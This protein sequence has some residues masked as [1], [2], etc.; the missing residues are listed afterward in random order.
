MAF[1]CESGMAFGIYVNRAKA[2]FTFH[3]MK[4]IFEAVEISI[5]VLPRIESRNGVSKTASKIKIDG[6]P[7]PRTLQI[8]QCSY[9]SS[10]HAYQSFPEARPASRVLASH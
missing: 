2:Q 8:T 7:L 5:D 3:I 4:T 1:L 6:H 9:S 10:H